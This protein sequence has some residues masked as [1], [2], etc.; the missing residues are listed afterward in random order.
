LIRGALALALVL[1][2][3]CATFHAAPPPG[4]PAGATFVDVD[5][6]RLHYRELG[7]GDD[8]PPVVLVHGFS[9]SVDT[10]RGVQ[11]A[12]ARDF[13]VIAFDLAG[14]GWSSRPAMDYSPVSQA[15]LLWRAL[16]RLG[17]GD[18][19]LVGHSWGSSV[20]LTM[21]V[22][23]PARVRRIALYAAYVYEAQVPSFFHWARLGGLGEAL[24]AAW[25]RERLEDR[26]ALAYHDD[27]YVTQ[28]R[29]EHV[30]AELARPGTVAAA[31]ATAR[32]QVYTELERHWPT[33]ACPVLLLWGAEDQ[34]TPLRYAHRLLRE[35]PDA[36]LKV[37]PATGH[38]PMVEARRPTTRD[39]HAFLRR[40]RPPPAADGP[41]LPPL[42]LPETLP[43]GAVD[44]LPLRAAAD[45]ALLGAELAPRRFAA[46]R[47]RTTVDLRG[48]LRIRG[49][50]LYNLDLDRGLDPSG[51]PL[52]PIPLDG[53]QRLDGADLRLRTDLAFHARGTGVA[54][55][56]RVDVLDNLV[57][58]STPAVGTGRAPTPAA[59]PGQ[60]PPLDAVRIERVWGEVLT[61]VG[62]LAA[63]R[64]GAHWGLGMV[65]HGGDCDD[66]DGGD[67][68]DRIALVSPLGGHL[69]A[70][71]YDVT[72]SGPLTARKD[73]AR[74]V[75]LAPADDVTT[76][77]LALLRTR[78]PAALLR[79]AAAGRASLEYGAFLSHRWQAEDVP[80]AYLPVAAPPGLDAGQLVARD[81]RATTAGAWVRLLLPRL[82][83]EA[84]AAYARAR[85]GQPS[86]VPGVEL[87]QPVT[88]DQVGLAVES[89]ARLGR[90]R[91]GVDAGFA[92]GD[93]APGFGAFPVPGAPA[94][95]PGDLDGPQASP[96]G[97][98]TVDNFRF[99][100][101]YRIDRIL[102]RE[103]I[104]TV[105]DAGYLRP[106]LAVPLLRLGHGWLEASAALVASWAIEPTST[107]SGARRLGIELDPSLAFATRD[108][109][110]VALDH[111]LFV[112]GPAF[113]GAGR[114]ARPAQLVRLRLG[115]LF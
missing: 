102:F 86:L 10:W 50:S 44:A 78:T 31:L 19:A 20:V 79:R 5:G 99:H 13:H 113:D 7:R 71:S 100:P 36:E 39:L 88:S 87:S 60:E 29:V 27:R 56:A 34:V 43:A 98:T 40:D 58:G 85:V 17:V 52:F 77:T 25:Y 114:A 47:D 14:F 46:P 105:T 59:S 24:F 12:L 35:L 41:A 18:V 101:D 81:F 11:E 107:P 61:P 97:D 93:D 22:E 110:R 2:A 111:A 4:A 48:H 30:E 75:E 73:G 33:I 94:P 67:A 103:I 112:P 63:G 37:Y 55:K 76:V 115:Y 54:V 95:R 70:L 3:G 64:M 106:H 28:A 83:V 91:V 1:G 38:I 65:A 96:P 68:A 15:R 21:A 74:A 26:V 84:E 49:E 9:A 72:W 109:L 45:L 92:S 62:I 32:G 104:G 53:G 6:V 69:I 80:A 42:P 51:Q 89:E 23:Q 90:V 16:D 108:G 82:R 8:R 57:L 66:C